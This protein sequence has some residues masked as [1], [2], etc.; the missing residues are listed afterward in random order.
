MIAVSD[1]VPPP[2]TVTLSEASATTD[3]C[4]LAPANCTV[5]FGLLFHTIGIISLTKKIEASIVEVI[6]ITPTKV[7]S[8]VFGTS[9][10]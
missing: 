1:I 8:V 4:G 5:A 2:V 10:G 7:I 6:H 3:V 9:E